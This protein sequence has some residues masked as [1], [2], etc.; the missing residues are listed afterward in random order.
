MDLVQ[1]TLAQRGT[2]SRAAAREEL[3]IADFGARISNT[4]RGGILS[5][6]ERVGT[7]EEAYQSPV[8][9]SQLSTIVSQLFTKTETGIWRLQ[10]L[11]VERNRTETRGLIQC[12]GSELTPTGL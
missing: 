12:N 10:I 9:L 1:W 4:G 5:S 3:R 2:S 7:R 11:S 6:R 8:L